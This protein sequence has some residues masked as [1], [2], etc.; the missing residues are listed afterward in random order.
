[1]TERFMGPAIRPYRSNNWEKLRNANF[2]TK[3]IYYT[4]DDAWL[5]FQR[6]NP[7][8]GQTTHLSGHF[9]S[10]GE[11]TMALVNSVLTLL[12]EVR[13]SSSLKSTVPDGLKLFS[14]YNASEFSKLFRG[15]YVA[16]AKPSLRGR[17]NMLLNKGINSLN[18]K[19]ETGNVVFT[20]VSTISKDNKDKK[21][22]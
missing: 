19:V 4:L 14:K 13:A 8:D 9:A 11:Y 21:D 12:P 22:K 18:A 6:M 3:E 2:V 1:V 20:T 10:K 16:S 17:L 15:T 5:V 7:L